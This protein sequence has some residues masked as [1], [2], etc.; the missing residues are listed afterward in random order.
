MIESISQSSAYETPINL[1]QKMMALTI[2]IIREVA[3]CKSALDKQLGTNKFQELVH[4]AF[5]IMGSFFAF[6]FFPYVGYIIDKTTGL[7]G[8]LEKTFRDL[9]LLYQKVID[10]HLHIER[11]VKLGS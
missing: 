6:D 11:H 10:D 2:H 5:S 4:E 1:T 9:D 7:H 8:R 3:L